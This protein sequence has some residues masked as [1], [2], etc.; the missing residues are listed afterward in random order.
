[1]RRLTVPASA[2]VLA[3]TV[4]ACGGSSE[5]RSTRTSTVDTVASSSTVLPPTTAPAPSPAEI[6]HAAALTARKPGF[7]ADV[8]ATIVVRKLGGTVTAIGSGHFDPA[9]GSGTLAASVGLPG[10]LGLVGPLPVQVRLVGGDA[11]VQLPADLASELGISTDWLEENIAVLGL[12]DSLSPSDILR[13]IARDATRPVPGQRA[14]VTIDPATGLVRTIAL[15]YT[16]PGGYHVHVVL[17]LTGFAT[18][19]ATPA[20]P[21]SQVGDLQTALTALGL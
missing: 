4:A 16:R 17:T 12:G 1:M 7:E 6:E 18:E 2:V 20:P 3:L 15:T 9:S 13:E 21:P 11:Y 10:L 19:P 5:H 8:T 14:H